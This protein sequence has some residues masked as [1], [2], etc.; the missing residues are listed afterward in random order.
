MENKTDYRVLNNL[1]PVELLRA[2]KKEIEDKEI[3]IYEWDR[4]SRMG[5][6]GAGSFGYV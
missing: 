6:I 5:I 3:N 4:F 1:Y 2:V